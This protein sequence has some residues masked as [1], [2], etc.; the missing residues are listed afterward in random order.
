MRNAFAASS[1]GRKGRRRGMSKV[2]FFIPHYCCLCKNTFLRLK[3]SLIE[4]IDGHCV[5]SDVFGEH[6]AATKAIPFLASF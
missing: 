2:H 5:L 3:N 6:A 4:M 1:A